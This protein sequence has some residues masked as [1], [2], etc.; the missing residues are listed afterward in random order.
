MTGVSD[1]FG[2]VMWPLLTVHN[3]G[4][5]HVVILLSIHGSA[6]ITVFS[7]KGTDM[8]MDWPGKRTLLGITLHKMLCG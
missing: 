5:G 7:K 6:E 8:V 4:G 2:I 3:C 1:W